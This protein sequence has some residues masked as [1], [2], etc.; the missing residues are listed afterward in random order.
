M[1]PR[2]RAFG[3]SNVFAA[4]SDVSVGTTVRTQIGGAVM[5]PTLILAAMAI[6]TIGVIAV[7][8][9]LASAE[10][11]PV[12]TIGLLEAE[13]YTVNIDRVGSAPLEEC[14]VTGVRNPQTVT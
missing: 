7:P 2:V 12:E 9:G 8:A 6:A 10:Q 14:I 11:S 1:W 5:R 4:C 3:S 13:G